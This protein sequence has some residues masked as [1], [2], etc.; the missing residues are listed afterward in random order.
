MMTDLSFRSAYQ[1]FLCFF[2]SA[3][4]GGNLVALVELRAVTA[5]FESFYHGTLADRA[6]GST[7]GELDSFGTAPHAVYGLGGDLIGMVHLAPFACCLFSQI[8]IIFDCGDSGV[9]FLA[10]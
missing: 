4:N 6:H 9:A 2:A 5:G 10:V 1:I 8:V 7:V 3:C